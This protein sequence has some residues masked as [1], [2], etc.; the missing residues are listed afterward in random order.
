[1]VL[2]DQGF[3][4]T[5]ASQSV[6]YFLTALS[7]GRTKTFIRRSEAGYE[8]MPMSEDQILN[9]AAAIPVIPLGVFIVLMIVA[10]VEFL[11]ADPHDRTRQFFTPGIY[12]WGGVIGM[13]I[14]WLMSLWVAIDF[15]FITSRTWNRSHI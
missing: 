15:F 4:K 3:P 2:S 8:R 13:G 12:S 7:I 5:P 11:R 9:I 14:V 6:G 1:M 10:I